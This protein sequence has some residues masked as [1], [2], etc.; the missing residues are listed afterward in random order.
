MGA[1]S[2]RYDILKNA[3]KAIA[4]GL[5]P[6]AALRAFTSDSAEILGLSDRMGS[7]TPGKIANLVVADGDIFG[8]KTKVKH[9][10]IDGRWFEIH[11]EPAAEKSGD[12]KADEPPGSPKDLGGDEGAGR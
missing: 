6:D 3:R 8:E 11:E 1:F 5:A 12:H 4:A 7:I 9:V 10:F 2:S